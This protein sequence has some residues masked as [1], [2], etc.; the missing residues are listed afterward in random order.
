MSVLWYLVCGAPRR[1]GWLVDEE[2]FPQ[3]NHYRAA[4]MFPSIVARRPTVQELPSTTTRLEGGARPMPQGTV[5][6]AIYAGSRK[7]CNEPYEGVG[8]KIR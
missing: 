4:T 8:W 5:A 2:T 7:P 6:L 3:S 1:F